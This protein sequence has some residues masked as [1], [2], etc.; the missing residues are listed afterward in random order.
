M[1][2]NKMWTS[3]LVAF[4]IPIMIVCFTWLAEY[5]GLEI[6]CVDSILTLIGILATFVVIGNYV[7]ITKLEKEI[8]SKNVETER[9][10][11]RMR[12]DINE[13]KA[14]IEKG[15]IADVNIKVDTILSAINNFSQS[16][17][18]ANNN[19]DIEH[20]KNIYQKVSE[21]KS[22]ILNNSRLS[23]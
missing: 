3:L 15:D 8:R 1:K 4:V 16:E 20:F 7:Q 22:S 13:L 23:K 10:L 6:R 18:N 12:I 14:Q 5:L 11:T 2:N 19:I 9:S 17:K 21:R